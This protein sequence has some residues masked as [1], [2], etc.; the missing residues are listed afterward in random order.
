M[1]HGVYGA[2]QHGYFEA[3]PNHDAIAFRVVDDAQAGTIYRK[4]A[5]HPGLRPH[6]F[7]L[8]NYPVATTTCTRSRR[9]CG[10]S[11]RG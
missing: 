9:A 4:I 8:P 7:I 5:S 10:R 6:R 1:K 3:S 2:P 11:A